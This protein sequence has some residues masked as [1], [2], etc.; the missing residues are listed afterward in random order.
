M[1]RQVGLPHNLRA[2]R[3]KPKNGPPLYFWPPSQDS[4]RVAM[5]KPPVSYLGSTVPATA[6]DIAVSVGTASC[7]GFACRALSL[8]PPSTSYTISARLH[9]YGKKKG[10]YRRARCSCYSEWL[11]ERGHGKKIVGET[12]ISTETRPG[13]IKIQRWISM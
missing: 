1:I 3:S 9:R 12:A 10:Y 7:A 4:C 11:P 8:R 6:C 2:P 5:V 13:K